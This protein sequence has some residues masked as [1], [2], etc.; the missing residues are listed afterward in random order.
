MFSKPILGSSILDLRVYF[1]FE[2]PGATDICIHPSVDP[3]ETG[4]TTLHNHPCGTRALSLA[5]GMRG[6]SS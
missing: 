5:D 3:E 4:F 1:R 6:T 2:V